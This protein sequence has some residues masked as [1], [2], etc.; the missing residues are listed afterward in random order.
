VT[1]IYAFAC[2]DSN[3][4]AVGF[5]A[6]ERVRVVERRRRGRAGRKREE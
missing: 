4:G 5:I 3:A 1:Y 2:G 6:V